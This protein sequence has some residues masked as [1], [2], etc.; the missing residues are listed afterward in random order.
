[1]QSEDIRSYLSKPYVTGEFLKQSIARDRGRRRQYQ[2]GIALHR[3]VLERGEMR[4]VESMLA[5]ALHLPLADALA[6]PVLMH[7]AESQTHRGP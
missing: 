4:H 3:L 5:A 7:H 1:M 2:F 6:L